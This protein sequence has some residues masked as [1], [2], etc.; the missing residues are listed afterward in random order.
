MKRVI[1]T[2][3]AIMGTLVASADDRAITKEQLPDNAR[4]FLHTHY[5]NHKV[6]A[7]TQDR[8]LFNS[9]YSAML[10]DGTKVDFDGNGN[11][12]TVKHHRGK[13]PQEII[14]AKI[15]SFVKEHFPASPIVK[16]DREHNGYEVELQGDIELKFDAALNC[17][18]IDR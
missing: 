12:E 13:I 1:F 7:A 4:K 18:D 2:I 14:P 10:D 3:F 15:L 17:I 6:I 16:I 11:W 9:D 8:E 5:A